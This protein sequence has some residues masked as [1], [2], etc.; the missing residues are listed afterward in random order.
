MET[1][2]GTVMPHRGRGTKLGVPTLNF[3]APLNIQDGVYAGYVVKDQQ[4]HPAAIFVGAA[5]TFHETSRQVE[6]HVLDRSI[7]L[8]GKITIELVQWLRGNQKFSSAEVLQKQM[9]QDIMTI[10]QCLPELS[11]IK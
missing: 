3:P 8:S 9:Q 11:K 5:I 1:I 6:A 4:R 7:S 10:K 2:R